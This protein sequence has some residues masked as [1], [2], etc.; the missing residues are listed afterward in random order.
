MP[1][2]ELA[3]G[4]LDRRIWV[5]VCELTR[6]TSN[7]TVKVWP[8]NGGS[9]FKRWAAK[10]EST[11]RENVGS[12]QLIRD[13]DTTF[14]LRWDADS[15]AIGPETHRVVYPLEDGSIYEIV[16]IAEGDGRKD[17]LKLLCSSRPDL[18]GPRGRGEAASEG[19]P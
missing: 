17:S 5:E 4:E 12:Q 10:K 3:A 18:T 8:P 6:D 13:F 14:T 9:R 16:G 11:G 2:K 7:D 1:I 15:R 19:E